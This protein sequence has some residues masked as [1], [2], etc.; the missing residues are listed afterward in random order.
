MRFIREDWILVKYVE[1]LIMILKAICKFNQEIRLRISTW[2]QGRDAR[3]SWWLNR[4]HQ[5]LEPG[6]SMKSQVDFEPFVPF[7]VGYCPSKPWRHQPW[8]RDFNRNVSNFC[9]FLLLKS[10]LLEFKMNVNN[11]NNCTSWACRGLAD[12]NKSRL[13]RAPITIWQR[14]LQIL[15]LNL[16]RI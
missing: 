1:K 9:A 10:V 4:W 13:G 6:H 5:A 14:D 11:V 3:W 15:Y 12:S 16:I 8:W 7:L 2:P